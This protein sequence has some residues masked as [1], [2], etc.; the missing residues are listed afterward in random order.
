MRLLVVLFYHTALSNI[1]MLSRYSYRW[2][3]VKKDTF[4]RAKMLLIAIFEG[5][6]KANFSA[7]VCF[8]VNFL[9]FA[10]ELDQA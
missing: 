4:S 7:C 3:G 10:F 1:Y 5:Y 6:Q 9:D 2:Q 8:D